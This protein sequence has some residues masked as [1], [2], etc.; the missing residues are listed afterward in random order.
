LLQKQ[1]GVLG[2]SQE[3]FQKC[4]QKPIANRNQEKVKISVEVWLSNT[5]EDN[6]V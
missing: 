4:L 2:I 5:S 1:I 6:T 3:N